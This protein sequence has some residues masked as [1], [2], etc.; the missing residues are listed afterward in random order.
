M[1]LV[2]LVY[3]EEGILVQD[4][5]RF[6]SSERIAKISEFVSFVFFLFF[7]LNRNKY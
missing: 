7:F 6:D 5:E 2:F 3:T 1:F 4:G